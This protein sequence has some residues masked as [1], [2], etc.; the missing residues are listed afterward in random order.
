MGQ[1]NGHRA[2]AYKVPGIDSAEWDVGGTIL[3]ASFE[4]SVAGT[5]QAYDNAVGPQGSA[6]I[7]CAS[8]RNTGKPNG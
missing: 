2:D 8:F 5:L 4:N 1:P 3:L 7:G 6:H